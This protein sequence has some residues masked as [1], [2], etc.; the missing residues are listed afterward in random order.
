MDRES[1]ESDSDAPPVPQLATNDSTAEAEILKIKTILHASDEEIRKI[2]EEILHTQA[3]LRELRR[4]KEALLQSTKNYRAVLSPA[5]VSLSSPIYRIPRDV[6]QEIFI[7]CLPQNRNPSMCSDEPPMLLSQVSSQW[8]DIARTTPQLWAAVHI[9]V[10]TDL[11]ESGAAY[12]EE[13]IQMRFAAV[14]EWLERSGA[15]PLSISAHEPTSSTRKPYFSTLLQH[16]L[17][18]VCGRFQH[19]D[20]MAYD[21][22]LSPLQHLDEDKTPLLK[23]VRLRTHSSP[24]YADIW[25]VTASRTVNWKASGGILASPSLR[26]LQVSLS[27]I[28]WERVRWSLL[29]NLDLDDGR[30]NGPPLRPTIE[31]LRQAKSLISLVLQPLSRETAP[32]DNSE[33]QEERPIELPSLKRLKVQEHPELSI[34]PRLRTPLLQILFYRRFSTSQVPSPLLQYLTLNADMTLEK[35]TTDH[36]SISAVELVEC[37]RCC[38][39]LR[40]LRLGDAFS[41]GSPVVYGIDAPNHPLNDNLLELFAPESS[42]ESNEVIC[43]NI[44]DIEIRNEGLFSEDG[45]ANFI[46]RK[47]GGLNG[48]ISKLRSFKVSFSKRQGRRNIK[49]EL[50]S[51]CEGL[52]VDLNYRHRGHRS[53]ISLYNGLPYSWMTD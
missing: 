50:A 36:L 30:G 45:V 35:L 52:R 41:D 49:M 27:D 6:M 17:I 12:L 8:R 15:L 7:A 32:V 10:P 33:V 48:R 47:Q 20:I 44:E 51:L 39:S 14:D 34:L 11:G 13:L 31:A 40:T 46:R 38:S 19:L 29:T 43:P 26:L 4:K 9:A 5:R 24:S 37:L 21:K 1:R 22:S 23:S 16:H 42:P 25:N 3:K 18:P 53:S 28:R 2:D